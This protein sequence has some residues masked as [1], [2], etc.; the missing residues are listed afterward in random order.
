ML[1]VGSV[2]IK[3]EHVAFFLPRDG[4]DGISNFSSFCICELPL[5]LFIIRPR[6]IQVEGLRLEYT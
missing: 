2:E 1:P 6:P 4:T 3:L 5:F